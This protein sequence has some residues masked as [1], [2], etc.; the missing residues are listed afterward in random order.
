MFSL[1][2][3]ILLLV[4]LFSILLLFLIEAVVLKATGALLVNVNI[5]VSI[6]LD[7]MSIKSGETVV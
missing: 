5:L 6:G 1:F 4:I 7:V 2:G 3:A